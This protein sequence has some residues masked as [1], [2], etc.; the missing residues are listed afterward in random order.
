MKRGERKLE[1]K[2]GAKFQESILNSLILAKS[3]EH[4]LF[5][6]IGEVFRTTDKRRALTLA[7]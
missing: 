5:E 6:L 2:L 4:R 1:K 7:F 3:R